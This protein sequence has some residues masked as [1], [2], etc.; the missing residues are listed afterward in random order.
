MPQE[1]LDLK[2]YTKLFQMRCDKTMNMGTKEASGYGQ[3]T[4]YLLFISMR[5]QALYQIPAL[6]DVQF[7]IKGVG[8]TFS[9]DECVIAVM[10]NDGTPSPVPIYVLE[11]KPRVPAG[12]KDIEPCHLSEL[13]LQA[14][15]LQ[16]SYSHVILH[17]LTDLEDFHC[18]EM[19]QCRPLKY[20]Y[21][22]CSLAEPEELLKHSNLICSILNQIT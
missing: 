13:F 1:P 18:F 4:D 15:Y 2:V 7:Q 14:N 19:K 5:M 8:K 6:I 21:T 22:K 9:A 17:V 12:L 20:Y 16:K 10:F 3:L 11:Y